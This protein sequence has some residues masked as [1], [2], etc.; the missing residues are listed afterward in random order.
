[1]RHLLIYITVLLVVAVGSAVAQPQPQ[2]FE[3]L[4][5]VPIMKGMEE[6]PEMALNF[7]KVG[8]RIAEAGAIA[9]DLSDREIMSF[10]KTALEQMGWQQIPLN[11]APY[12]FTREGEEL[13][14][15]LEKSDTSILVR[16]LLQPQG[17]S[18]P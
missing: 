9:P 17:A 15:F 5:D 12:K 1:M 16:F 18:T 11:F 3:T 4:Y 8:G 6:L 10:Y 7:D 14:I 13:S 2:F